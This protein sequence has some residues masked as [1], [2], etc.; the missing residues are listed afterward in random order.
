MGLLLALDAGLLHNQRT[1]I[2]G[3]VLRAGCLYTLRNILV[4]K[5]VVNSDTCSIN[6]IFFGLLFQIFEVSLLI[7]KHF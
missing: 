2:F 7:T 5:G 1:A 3:N 6:N 4:M